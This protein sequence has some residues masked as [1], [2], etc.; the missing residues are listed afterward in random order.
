MRRLSLLIVQIC[1]TA[2]L[3]FCSSLICSSLALAVQLPQTGQSSCY[4]SSG[5]TIPCSGTGQDGDRQA[6]LP[7]PNPRFTVGTG[8]QD[9]C[10]T[11][12]LTGLVW[13]KT[14]DSTLRNWQGALNYANNLN[15]CG[16]SDWRLPTIVELESMVNAGELNTVAWL[17]EQQGFSEVQ[18]GEQ[19]Y[20]SS[21]TGVGYTKIYPGDVALSVDM[22]SGNMKTELNDKTKTEYAWP[23]RGGK[24][25]APAGIWKTGQTKCYGGAYPWGEISCS[26]TGQDG[27]LLPGVAWPNPR[28]SD[29]RDGTVTDNLTGLIWLKNANCKETVGG[30]SKG[31]G[32][33]TWSDALIWS[34]NLASGKC[35]LT[36]DSQVGH[37]RLPN[38]QEMLSLVDF[39]YA[40]PALSNAAG[41]AQGLSN[42][43]PGDPFDFV[44]SEFYWSS[45]SCAS[46]PGTAWGVSMW[47]GGLYNY[48]N[49][50]IDEYKHFV[51]P[52]SG[53]GQDWPFG[54]LTITKESGSGMVTS[55]PAG[56][57]CGILDD[58]CSMYLPLNQVVILSGTPSADSSM[59]LGWSAGDCSDGVVTM[60]TDISCTAAFGV[61]QNYPARIGTTVYSSIGDIGGAYE[62][63]MSGDTIEVMASYPEETLDFNLGKAVTLEGGYD[64]Q[65][66]LLPYSYS[67]IIGS[68]TI[69]SGTVTV[70][71]IAIQ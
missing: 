16:F 1:C 36:D 3:L 60:S 19:G 25:A 58:T 26:D 45:T 31:T 13:V 42:S 30:I 4:T 70:D 56:I 35:G 57:N 66:I 49:A 2:V 53:G 67:T 23:V 29:N 9:A 12:N 24:T 33:L 34:N 5:G 50:D 40:N 20:W 69:E 32:V 68:L 10:V 62:T 28:F 11:D 8:A 54:K 55:T 17:N 41:T 65:F 51:W 61:C 47:G 39:K 43:S 38:R 21:T 6:G 7:W 27:D 46:V 22:A 64:C 15:L 18:E 59:L 48:F 44:K 63:A 52:V 14:P 71:G 37:W